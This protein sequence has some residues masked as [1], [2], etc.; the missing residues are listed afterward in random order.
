MRDLKG[1]KLPTG[2]QVREP[3]TGQ[4]PEGGHLQAA[5]P[6]WPPGPWT[7]DGTSA[8][9]AR[10]RSPTSTRSHASVSLD[11]VDER[12][13][14]TVGLEVDVEAGFGQSVEEFGQRRD[15]VLAR[16]ASRRRPRRRTSSR[17]GADAVGDPVEAI[18]VKGEQHAVTR[19]VDVSLEVDVAQRRRRAGRPRACSRSLD[20]PGARHRRGGPWR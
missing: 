8:A 11:E 1:L 4:Q 13:D 12:L 5:P 18:V 19:G 7:V 10:R 3:A 16:D 20:S 14:G 6:R 2:E 17:D 15:V 9:A